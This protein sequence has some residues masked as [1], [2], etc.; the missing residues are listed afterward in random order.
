M[1]TL[2]SDEIVKIVRA[3]EAGETVL[4]SQKRSG[5]W[6]P[7][8]G[9]M[10]LNFSSFDYKIQV[11]PANVYGVR[12]NGRLQGT[13]RTDPEVVKSIALEHYQLR[14]GEY[15]LVEFVEKT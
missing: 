12:I 8:L 3:V 15:E 4:Y 7:W 9:G 10:E 13:F 1:D 2:R 5:N 14:G 6:M 11:E